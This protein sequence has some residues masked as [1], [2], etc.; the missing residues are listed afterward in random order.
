MSESAHD[1]NPAPGAEL[2]QVEAL[3]RLLSGAPGHIL[4]NHDG[5]LP[6]DPAQVLEGLREPLR[7]SADFRADFITAMGRLAADPQRGWLLMYYLVDLLG[8][9]EASLD[10]ALLDADLLR[11]WGASLALHEA[12]LRADHSDG[13]EMYPDGRWGD[14]RRLDAI[15]TEAHGVHVL[16]QVEGEP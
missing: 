9:F 10:V 13:A 5:Y 6:T 11:F 3:F 16:P 7:E 2:S 15:L 4:H 8:H 12:T 1:H 14:V